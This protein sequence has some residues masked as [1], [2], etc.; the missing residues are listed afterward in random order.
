[1]AFTGNRP[2][3]KPVSQAWVQSGCQVR[4]EIR[5]TDFAEKNTAL[6]R[7]EYNLKKADFAQKTKWLQDLEDAKV[8]YTARYNATW[9]AR[10]ESC[11]RA[12][13]VAASI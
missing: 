2:K 1:M 9:R 4:K 5:T 10:Y 11:L 12:L 6:R 7:N 13:T 3:Y 8:K